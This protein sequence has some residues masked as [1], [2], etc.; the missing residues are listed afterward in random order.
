M[1]RR[2]RIEH[3]LN[4]EYC[5]VFLTVEDESHTHHVPEGAETHYKIIMAADVF[6]S[7]PRIKRHQL[8]NKLLKN[9]LDT[10]M[11]ALSMHLY[12]PT[13]WQ[14]Q[15][16]AILKSPSCRDGYKNK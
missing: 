11:H 7:L 2:E 8:L 1:S 3:L 12:C 9:E 5:P 10:G 4:T 15:S 13:E 16:S 14:T 6:S